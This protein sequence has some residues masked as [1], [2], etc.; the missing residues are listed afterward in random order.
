MVMSQQSQSVADVQ[1]NLSNQ[2]FGHVSYSMCQTLTCQ[3]DHSE[4]IPAA[5]VAV[6]ALLHISADTR[7]CIRVLFS[8]LERWCVFVP[9]G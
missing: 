3:H 5:A 1:N 6:H 4:V 2:H 8:F 7:L 9:S